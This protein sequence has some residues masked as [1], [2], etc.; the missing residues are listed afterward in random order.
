MEKLCSHMDCTQ[1]QIMGAA[2]VVDKAQVKMLNDPD[3]WFKY[4]GSVVEKR[5]LHV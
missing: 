3:E 1:L 2:A 4:H 5:G